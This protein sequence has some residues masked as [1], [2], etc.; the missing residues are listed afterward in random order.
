M[1]DRDFEFDRLPATL[2]RRLNQFA[3]A[4]FTTSMAEAGLDLTPVQFC[5]LAAL[6]AHPGVDQATLAGL[7]GYDRATLGKVV[8]RLE[9]KTLLK[10]QIP[11]NDRR[12][13]SL[14]L[15]R[16]GAELLVRAE[17][18]VEQLQPDILAGLT[19]AEQSRLVSLL[20]KLLCA[21]ERGAHDAPPM[22]SSRSEDP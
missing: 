1:P 13:R 6:H 20:G 11:A 14:H 21:L 9:T 2:I 7:I 18:L 16:A 17:P 15:T 4:R 12:A 10:R 8:G 5:A 3:V 22:L 19:P